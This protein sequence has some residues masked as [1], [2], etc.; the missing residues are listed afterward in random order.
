MES[1]QALLAAG[2]A[3]SIVGFLYR[4]HRQDRALSPPARDVYDASQGFNEF[5][6]EAHGPIRIFESEFRASEVLFHM[7]PESYR[8]HLAEYDGGAGDA[9][10]VAGDAPGVAP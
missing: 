9:E 7:E 1:V 10:P 8:I 3:D 2:A 5:V 6:D 4:I